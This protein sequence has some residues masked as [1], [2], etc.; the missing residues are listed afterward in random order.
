MAMTQKI[1]IPMEN[2]KLSTH[3]GHCEYFAIIDV[4]DKKIAEITKTGA[5]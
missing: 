3:F 4:Q 1:A 2:G 5:T